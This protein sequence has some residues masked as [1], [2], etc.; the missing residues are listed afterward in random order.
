MAC[1]TVLSLTACGTVPA[2]D[3]VCP[4]TD[5]ARTDLAGAL[6]EDGGPQSKRAGLALIETLD[7]VCP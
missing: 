7:R 6:V 1:L 3:P 2:G 4:S 5:R